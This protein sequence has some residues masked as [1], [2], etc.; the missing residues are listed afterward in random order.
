MTLGEFIRLHKNDEIEVWDKE[1][2]IRAPY[3][4]YESFCFDSE[5]EDDKNLLKI[6]KWIQSL[7]VDSVWD[8]TSCTVNVYAEIE[9]NW[10]H[11]VDCIREHGGYADYFNDDEI[12][13]DDEVIAEYTEDVF[14]T[15]SQGHYG[16]ARDFCEFMN[17]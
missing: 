1:V 13:D 16:F 12:L 5:D 6:E 15:L 8:G 7:E 3:Y 2:D 10:K 11:I 14:T 9:K 4:V 17:L